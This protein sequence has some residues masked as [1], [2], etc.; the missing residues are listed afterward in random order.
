M[1]LDV[2][3]YVIERTCVFDSNIT[4]NLAEMADAVGIYQHCWRPEELGITHAKQLIEPLQKGLELLKS[5]PDKYKKYD[6][7]NGWGK[8]DN[9]VPWVEKYLEACREYPDAEV[10]ASR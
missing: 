7:P 9:F 5:D 6:S 1:S 8:Y 2:S 4:H 3:L 10:R